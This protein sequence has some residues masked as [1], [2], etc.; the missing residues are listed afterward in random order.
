MTGPEN[1]QMAQDLLAQADGEEVPRYADSLRASA[2]VHATLALTAATAL[3]TYHGSSGMPEPDN[4]A[5][6]RVAS[7]GPGAKA[8]TKAAEAAELAE[9]SRDIPATPEQEN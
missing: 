5:W 3:S 8:R 7:E 9:Y 6:Y 1:Y 4:Q 2:L